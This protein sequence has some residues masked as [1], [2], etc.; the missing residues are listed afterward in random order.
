MTINEY[1]SDWSK[2][3][4][5]NEADRIMKKLSASKTTIC[6]NLKDIFKAF[7]LCPLDSLKAIILAQDPYPTLKQSVQGSSASLSIPV[8]TGLAFA[9]SP[10]TPETQLSPSLDILRNSVIDFTVPHNCINFDP[11]L[12]KWERQGVL[13]LNS[14]LSCEAGKAGSHTLL[15]RN[16]MKVLLTKLSEYHTGIVYILMGKVAESFGS[17]IDETHNYVLHIRHP[18]WYA[19][20]KKQMPSDI[21]RKVDDILTQQYGY[22]IEWYQEFN[23]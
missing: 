20:E 1:F 10:D 19:R 5:L 6:P 17:Y 4:D 15:W 22:G 13:L 11:S 3:I 23:L 7:R 8:A 21:W 16:F 9:N 12:E 18:S 14:A 2:V